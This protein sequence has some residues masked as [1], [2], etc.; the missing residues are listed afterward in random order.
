MLRSVAD[1]AVVTPS[2]GVDGMRK[3]ARR[4][5]ALSSQCAL[6]VKKGTGNEEG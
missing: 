1:A 2:N 3:P 4:R 5:D 6:E